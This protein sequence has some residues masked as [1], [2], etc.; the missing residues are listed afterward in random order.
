MYFFNKKIINNILFNCLLLDCCCNYEDVLASG[1]GAMNIGST[2]VRNITTKP[3]SPQTTSED[4]KI[5]LANIQFLQN[6]SNILT[7]KQL[8]NLNYI[9]NKSYKNNSQN[10]ALP[11]YHGSNNDVQLMNIRTGKSNELFSYVILNNIQNTFKII[12]RFN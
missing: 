9:F 11:D 1:T 6:A 12:Y 5:Y 3:L 10:N 7:S 8:K 4:F 2:N